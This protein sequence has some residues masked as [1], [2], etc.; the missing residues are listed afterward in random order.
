MKIGAEYV[1]AASGSPHTPSLGGAAGGGGLV[2]QGK[3]KLGKQSR[4]HQNTSEVCVKRQKRP[5]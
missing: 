4:S 2:V 5:N 3:Y 1:M